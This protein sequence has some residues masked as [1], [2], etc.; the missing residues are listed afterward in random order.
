MCRTVAGQ[1]PSVKVGVQVVAG[2]LPHRLEGVVAAVARVGGVIAHTFVEDGVRAQ[3]VRIA[4][5]HLVPCVDLVSRMLR[6][7]ADRLGCPPLGHSGVYRVNC[8]WYSQL[9]E[10]IHY[11]IKHDDGARPE[12]WAEADCLILG[13]SRAGKSP[14]SMF[15]ATMGFKVANYPICPGVDIPEEISLVPRGRC[16]GLVI[17]P[18]VLAA[19]RA[20]RAVAEACRKGLEGLQAYTDLPAVFEE[21]EAVE[22]YFKQKR[23]TRVDVTGQTVQATA[24]K[25][26]RILHSR[27]DDEDSDEGDA[28]GADHG[29]PVRCPR[30]QGYEDLNGSLSPSAAS[31]PRPSPSTW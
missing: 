2:V 24:K 7:V 15:L 20:H 22:K 16:F 21:T 27:Y 4:E 25:V 8:A 10:A 9:S 1:F 3:I 19:H 31:P 13:V 14:L 28:D 12:E 5:A 29:K 6:M 23:I 11:A 18:E 26:I 30:F 17:D